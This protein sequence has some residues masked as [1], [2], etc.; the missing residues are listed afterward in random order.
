[1]RINSALSKR[2]PKLI[3][4]KETDTLVD[5]ARVLFEARLGLA[6]ILGPKGT[7]KGVI[8]ERDIVYALGRDGRN[9]INDTVGSI[10]TRDVMTATPHKTMETAMADM[11]KRGIRHMPV[12]K[13][14]K[15][16]DVLSMRDAMKYYN[17]TATD[18]ERAM[19]FAKIAW[20]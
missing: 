18:H 20:V 2:P 3:T 17:E 7:L 6:V 11:A 14:D 16:I 13:D 1:M 10:M 19:L 4:V 5:A 8:S 15:V 12:L 9:G